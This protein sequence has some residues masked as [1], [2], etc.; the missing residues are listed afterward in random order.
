MVSI[1][2]DEVIEKA[3]LTYVGIDARSDS[4]DAVP[5]VITEV[6]PRGPAAKAGILAGDT[7]TGWDVGRRSNPP[8]IGREVTTKYRLALN[9]IP[10]GAK[11]V[12][13]DVVRD[14]KAIKVEIS[15][16]LIAGGERKS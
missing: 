14:G 2:Y 6:D 11:T 10:S 12:V 8:I 7:I 15:P 3:S 4:A 5:A 16:Q 9:L 13:F 1:G